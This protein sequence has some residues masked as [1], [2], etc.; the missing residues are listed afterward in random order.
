[1]NEDDW[2]IREH[3]PIAE[4]WADSKTDGLQFRGIT[5]ITI[6]PCVS[7]GCARNATTNGINT[8]NQCEGR[9]QAEAPK[10]RSTLFTA[11][12]RS[13]ARTSALRDTEKAWKESEADF[14]SRLSVCSKK[15]NRHSCSL[16]TCPV[17]A[18]VA[19]NEWGKNWPRQG[20]IVDGKLF[21]LRKLERPLSENGGSCW[22]RPLAT[23]ASKG[24]PNANDHGVPKLSAIAARW[25]RLR[26]LDWKDGM[27]RSPYGQHS[28]AIGIQARKT[29]H[30]GYLSPRFHVAMMG[31]DSEW[32]ALGD[33]ETLW[34]LSKRGRLLKDY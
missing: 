18:P 8:T 1:M 3:A 12:S 33:L 13:C 34:F 7:D 2:L 32:T 21:P 29:G 27:T 28:D 24:G 16:K 4:I 17:S 15:S 14:F 5:T 10:I 26:A 19:E 31:Y 23:D 9:N 25:A 11:A 30:L 6:N 20:M 22:P